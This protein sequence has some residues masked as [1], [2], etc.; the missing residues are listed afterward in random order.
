[1]KT[2]IIWLLSALVLASAQS[3]G[4]IENFR[5][6]SNTIDTIVL[7]WSLVGGDVP[8]SKYTLI[9]DD[10][11]TQ[12]V[13]CP[14]QYCTHEVDYLD[15][16]TVYDFKLIPH[17]KDGVDG[18]TAVTS[19]HTVEM[20]P[21][22]PTNP[23]ASSSS[24]GILV[25]WQAPAENPN[26]VDKYIVCAR[27]K[28]DLDTNCQETYDLTL[29][30]EEIQLCSTYVITIHASTPT[31]QMGPESAAEATT[32]EGVPGIPENVI[33]TLSTQTM[34]TITYDDP[35]KNPRCVVEFGVIYG[36]IDRRIKTVDSSRGNGKHEHTI[37]PLDACT[38]YSIG[39]YGVNPSEKKGPTAVQ[40]AATADT[41]PF[42]PHYLIV[43]P[44]GPDSVDASWPGD[45]TNK[46]A[47]SLTV[48]WTDHIHPVEFCEDI[49]DRDIIDGGGSFTITD[50]LP[51]SN[52]EVTITAHS[53]TGMSSPTLANWTFTDDITPGPVENLK[54]KEVEVTRIAI[55]YD[56]PSDQA[57]CVKE[58]DT[59]VINLD[60]GGPT[61]LEDGPFVVG[62][63]ES[64]TELDA[65]TNYALHVRTVTRTGLVS[66]WT[67]VQTT[68]GDAL[69]SEA[70][71][72]Q[73]HDATEDSLA[74]YWF[75]PELNKRCAI[76]YRL[77]WNS[78]DDSGSETIDLTPPLPF[79]VTHTISGLK[80]CTDY[81]LTLIAISAT[82]GESAAATLS[83]STGGCG[84]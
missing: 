65:C 79:E 69:P 26:C 7:E 44:T 41:E 75:Q 14:V 61:T 9:Y 3:Y 20:I 68:T 70:R 27:I 10:D 46:C 18:E 11:F 15:A 2:G 47:D 64:H 63:D 45:P 53:P 29:L 72:F 76:A 6:K 59:R 23:S 1:M 48:C 24:S 36:E 30:L 66:N 78:G 58:Y 56:P 8:V 37:S 81:Q 42:P 40:Y 82:A 12:D 51:C 38:N 55:S 74:L 43:D 19:G 49:F 62:I 21:G 13:R 71:N 34:I 39:V 16:C 4:V 67:I 32:S 60:E 73:L 22:E 35:L 83:A 57:Q 54:V 77:S 84:L 33:V 5:M 52:Y 80:A 25:T 28:G 50:L 31:G 17:F